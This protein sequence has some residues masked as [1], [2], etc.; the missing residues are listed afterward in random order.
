MP[1][2]GDIF[3]AAMRFEMPEDVEA[4]NTFVFELINGTATDSDILTTAAAILS[5]AYGY[6]DSF[7][8]TLVND[9][10]CKV[11]ELIWSGT[12]WVVDRIVGIAYPTVTT[13][14]VGQMLPHACA[15]VV[16]LMTT[17]PKCR[18]RKFIMGLTELDCEKST[19]SAA[20]LAAAVNFG[21]ALIN[22]AVCGNGHLVYRVASKNGDAVPSDAVRVNSTIGSCRRRKPGVGV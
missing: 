22:P 6:V 7:M 19:I 11:N 15:P 20:F 14:S 18:G 9:Q 16:E 2:P 17:K 1:S 4:Y 3:E 5:S 10:E 13:A 21:L 8:S 12:K